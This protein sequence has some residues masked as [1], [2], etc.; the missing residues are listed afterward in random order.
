VYR[1]DADAEERQRLKTWYKTDCVNGDRTGLDLYK[2]DLFAV[3]T[4]LM[5][6]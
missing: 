4:A 1:G 2:W 5:R 3:N 6:A